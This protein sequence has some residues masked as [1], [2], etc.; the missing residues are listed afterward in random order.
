[1]T[2]LPERDRQYL[3]DRG[4]MWEEVVDG[5][6][7]GIIFLNFNLPAERFNVPTAN[8]LIVLP[9]LYP[10]APPDMFY[11]S[12]QLKLAATG[13][14]PRATEVTF[15]FHG[16]SWQRWSRHNNEWRPGI[17]GISTMLKRVEHALE[18]AA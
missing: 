1:M 2:F 7:K 15:S 9:G 4:L 3:S 13:A 10:D 6:N 12:P 16:Q 18:V 11:S 17:D 5:A 14:L 8:I